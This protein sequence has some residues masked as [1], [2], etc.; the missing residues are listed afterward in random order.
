MN[1]LLK[2][3]QLIYALYAFLL[4]TILMLVVF[5]FAFI[6]SFWGRIKGGN[7]IYNISRLWADV[8][9]F[10]IGIRH[11]NIFLSPLNNNRQYIFVANHISFLDVP[12][13][14]KSTR[15]HRIRVLGKYEMQ[16]VPV[17]GFIYRNGA[18]MV[19]RSNPENRANSVQILKSVLRKGISI[20]I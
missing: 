10:L 5:P 16:R 18:V 6:A 9:I 1:I 13:L 2:L 4:F 7:F 12:S 3:A 19:N 15:Q 14:L 20:F 8:W 11:Q 17:F